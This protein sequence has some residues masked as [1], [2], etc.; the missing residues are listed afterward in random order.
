MVIIL[1]C[2]IIPLFHEVF[3]YKSLNEMIEFHEILQKHLI[4]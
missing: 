4:L 2:Q 1:F 3:F